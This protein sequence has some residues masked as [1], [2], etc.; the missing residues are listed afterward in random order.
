MARRFRVV[1]K[2]ADIPEIFMYQHLRV[3]DG[4]CFQDIALQSSLRNGLKYLL[5]LL[6]LHEIPY[7]VLQF[8]VTSDFTCI[9]RFNSL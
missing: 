9:S 3:S 2:Y 4:K 7:L 5:D 6:L 1:V 8:Y